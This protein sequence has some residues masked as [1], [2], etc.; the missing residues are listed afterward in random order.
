MGHQK[1][2]KSMIKKAGLFIYLL[3]IGCTSESQL[4][5]KVSVQKSKVNFTNTLNSEDQLTLL[6]YLYYYNGGGVAVGDINNDGLPDIYF[7]GNQTENKLYLNQGNLEF[8]DITSNANVGGGSSWNTGTV[9]AD[10]NGDGWLDIYVCAVVGLKGFYGYN[11]L[12][13]NNQDNT[14]TESAKDYGLD[15]ESF[16]SSAAFL[17]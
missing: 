11:E 16:S 4:F 8:K 10:V 6:D 12:Y 13:I 14:F 7:S 3:F 15:I 1:H 5:E 17:D 2:L 9:M